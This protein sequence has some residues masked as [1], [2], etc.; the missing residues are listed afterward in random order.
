MG[1]KRF[2]ALAALSAAA[3]FS[4]YA[5]DLDETPAV[6]AVEAQAR[7]AWRDTIEHTAVPEIDTRTATP[8]AIALGQSCFH[9]SY[10]STIW[11]KVDC[12]EAPNRPY[13]PRHPALAETV[14]NGN[15]YAAE[16]TPLMT[17]S[18][19]TFPTVTG[20]TRESDGAANT[21]S[22][23]LNS[24]FMTTAA[25]KGISGCLSWEQFV[26][27]S[28]EQAAFMQYWLIGYGSCPSG[29]NAYSP[30]CYKNSAAVKVPK[31]VITQLKNLKLSGAAVANSNDTLV[32][33]TATEAYSTTGKDSVVD[34]ATDWHA[35]EFNIIG[36]GG[37]SEAVFNKGSSV[38]VKI[39][40]TDGSTTAPRCV[41]DDGTTGETNNLTLK[42]CTAAGG[43]TPSIQFVE[44]N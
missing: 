11:S 43:S 7:E 24:N 4:A 38:T 5:Q 14:G 10:P 18:V 22:I 32:F 35:S 41:A 25:C 36:D 12:T 34:L 19:G 27:S 20:V 29:W 17:K 33:T 16:V 21:Y 8:E 15:D 6:D 28:G 9:A 3:V 37:G 39:T 26:Y 31:E 44:S 2:A 40:V 23:Q 30:D 1:K 42:T 13:T